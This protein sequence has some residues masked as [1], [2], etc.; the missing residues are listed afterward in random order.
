VEEEAS[1]A[2]PAAT[3][4]EVPAQTELTAGPVE[5][6]T[7]LCCQQSVESPRYVSIVAEAQENSPNLFYIPSMGF[8]NLTGTI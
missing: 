2:T 4:V 6:G 7:E 1:D 8:A 5:D 3:P